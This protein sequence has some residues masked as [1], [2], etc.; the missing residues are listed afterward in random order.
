M[1]GGVKRKK[2]K[3]KTLNIGRIIGR[4][5]EKVGARTR[6]KYMHREEIAP[7]FGGRGGGNRRVDAH[8]LILQ[9]IK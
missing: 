2:K 3:K 9:S 8:S 7:V 4:G 5:K 1:P 6:M